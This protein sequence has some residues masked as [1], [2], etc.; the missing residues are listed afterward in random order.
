MF[1]DPSD[2]YSEDKR[3]KMLKSEGDSV[4]N[5]TQTQLFF[6]NIFAFLGKHPTSLWSFNDI[7]DRLKLRSE[8]YLGLQSVPVKRIVGSV[9]RYEDFT[10]EF[11]P[12]RKE[13]RDRWSNVYTVVVRDGGMPPVE[14]YKIDDVYF[15][16]DGNHRVSV[17]RQLDVV[18]IDAFVIELTTPIDLEPGMS[19][20]QWHSAQAY[21]DF[22]EATELNRTRPDQ[23]PITLTEPVRY[24]DLLEH[25]ELVKLFRSKKLGQEI[26]FA[27]ATLVW[28]DEVF[29]PIVN[30]IEET[31]VME[32][33]KERTTAD[34]YVWMIDRVVQ[35][36]EEYGTEKA[37][38]FY[39]E[40]GIKEFLKEH[41]IPIPE[42]VEAIYDESAEETGDTD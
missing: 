21:A 32:H 14:L 16:R 31:D 4:F 15:V 6:Q 12:K 19:K 2:D 38:L 34:L 36:I 33:F 35:L 29:A 27:D 30:I 39:L 28:Y 26:S 17:A 1:F 24:H 25:I 41:N 7:R 18:E 3:K 9:G 40:E 20:E 23:K 13:M 11:L 22:L 37:G 10:G 42:S 5:N 8:I